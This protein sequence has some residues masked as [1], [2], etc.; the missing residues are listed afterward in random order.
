MLIPRRPLQ[1]YALDSSR[2]DLGPA[3]ESWLAGCLAYGVRLE[4][5]TELAGAGEPVDSKALEAV[6]EQYGLL[7]ARPEPRNKPE[8]AGILELTA[9]VAVEAE[10]RAALHMAYCTLALLDRI[11][12]SDIPLE[13]GR[14]LAL[15]ARVAR[16]AGAPN[17]AE[18]LYRRV[19]RIARELP[20]DEL[21]ARALV[22]RGVLAQARGNYPEARRLYTQATR[23][24]IASGDRPLIRLAHHGLMVVS[25]KF[26]QF[27]QAFLAGW[28]AFEGAAGNPQAEAES[29]LN[30][31]QL[32]LDVGEPRA[33]LH[34]FAAALAKEPAPW[35][36]LP[37][38]G[39]AALAAAA[40]QREDVVRECVSR[41]ESFGLNDTAFAYSRAAALLDAS[42]A[43]L[44]MSLTAE[45]TRT[46]ARALEL[47]NAHAYHEV[48]IGAEQIMAA[49]TAPP[50][51]VQGLLQQ[52]AHERAPHATDPDSREIL[53]RL[54]ALEYRGRMLAHPR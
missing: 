8:I 38:L 53:K 22:G 49:A 44:R 25:A 7:R 39:G 29:L 26:G 16:K 54:A 43:C 28:V 3:E 47:A 1:A 34:A 37:A 51:E 23:K 15:R 2:P 18:E 24:A 41:I 27:R 48:A 6:V 20:S 42:K 10:D 40:L 30:L 9:A 45:G 11:P 13:Y 17:I 14:I 5:I 19:D 46:A 52:L 35:L 31:A 4:S 33:A 32:A 50:R 21:R 36:R 12:H